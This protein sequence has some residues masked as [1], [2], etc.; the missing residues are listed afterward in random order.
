[1][2]TIALLAC[3]FL[4]GAQKVVGLKGGINISN[5]ANTF[6]AG[7]DE[8]NN[9]QSFHAGITANFPALLFSFQ[10]S[11][12]VTGKGSQVTY[13]DPYSGGD[14]FVT[15]TNPIYLEVPATFNL[16]LHF[17]GKTGVYAGAGPYF[18]MGFAGR[19]STHGRNN[20]T[21]FSHSEKIDYSDDDPTTPAEEGAAYG[22][23]KRFDYGLTVNAGAILAGLMVSAFYDFGFPQINSMSNA[24]QNDNLKNRTLGFSVGFMFGGND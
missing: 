4:A 12:L 20:G 23:L 9:L 21:D 11:L 3:S 16:N 7:V 10:P 1:M 24:G 14:Y 19:Q 13:G 6:E 2:M 18:A 8:S 15:T 5:L 17:G 22:R